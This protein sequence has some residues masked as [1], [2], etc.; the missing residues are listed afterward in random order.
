LLRRKKFEQL[1]TELVHQRDVIRQLVSEGVKS[2]AD[3]GWLIHM[4]FYWDAKETDVLK[5]LSIKMAN[6][7]F[8]YGYEYLGVQDRLVQ[9]P[10]TDR[11][12]LTLTQ[13]Y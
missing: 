1:I 2:A 10:L 3:F 12:F 8:D 5:A 7:S 4:R 9:T 11:C 6:S 13:V